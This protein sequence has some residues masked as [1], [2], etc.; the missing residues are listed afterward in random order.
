MPSRTKSNVS[1]DLGELRLISDFVRMRAAVNSL[2][3]SDYGW[4]AHVHTPDDVLDMGNLPKSWKM[5]GLSAHVQVKNAQCG[6]GEGGI[7][8]CVDCRVE[9]RHSDVLFLH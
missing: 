2:S 4:D 3:Q 6:I 9:D 1:G 8:P 7:P 5:S